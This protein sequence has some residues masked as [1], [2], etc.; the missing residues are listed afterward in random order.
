MQYLRLERQ[1]NTLPVMPRA[2]APPAQLA[3]GAAPG[4]APALAAGAVGS[5]GRASVPAPV[6]ELQD[7]VVQYRPGLPPALAGV[8]LLLE[9]GGH[10]GVCGRTGAGKSSLVAAVM[11]LVEVVSGAPRT[12]RA[13]GE[14]DVTPSQGAGNACCSCC[15][16]RWTAH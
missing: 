5:A 13:G 2:P 7:V 15:A 9:A 6:L 16:M 11:R 12:G 3:A 14:G 8:S 10:V 1:P 4:A